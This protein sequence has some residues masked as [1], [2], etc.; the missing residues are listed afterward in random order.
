MRLEEVLSL[1]VGNQL[2][3]YLQYTHTCRYVQYTTSI[4]IHTYIH[5][6]HLPTNPYQAFFS[7]TSKKAHEEEEEDD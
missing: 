2:G 7:S 6:L 5:K 4:Y 1:D 3:F